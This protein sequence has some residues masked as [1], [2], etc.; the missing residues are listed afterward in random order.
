[1][2]PTQSVLS[3]IRILKLILARWVMREFVE[4]DIDDITFGKM[5]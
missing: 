2:V 1:M 4:K 3:P 5:S